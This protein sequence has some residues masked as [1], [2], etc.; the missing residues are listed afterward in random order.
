VTGGKLGPLRRPRHQGTR[1]GRGYEPLGGAIQDRHRLGGKRG[2][3]PPFGPSARQSVHRWSREPR[4]P[5]C[6]NQPA[7]STADYAGMV[8]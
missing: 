3:I 5:R 1:Y 4:C 6:Y 2:R 7:S 8:Q